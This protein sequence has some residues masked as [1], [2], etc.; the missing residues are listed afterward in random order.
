[1]VA[2][3][4]VYNINVKKMKKMKNKTVLI[5]LTLLISVNSCK[6]D[7]EIEDKQNKFNPL[8]GVFTSDEC[9]GV[10]SLLSQRIAFPTDSSFHQSYYSFSGKIQS[11]KYG[12]LNAINLFA[13]TLSLNSNTIQVDSSNHYFQDIVGATGQT[14]YGTNI[15]FVLDGDSSNSINPISFTMY[16]PAEIR[17]N[18]P[19]LLNLYKTSVTN[20]ITWN[21]DPNNS[22]DVFIRVVYKGAISQHYD[23]NLPANDVVFETTVADNGTYT[24]PSNALN[25]IP[26]GGIAE[27]MIGRGNYEEI[28][29]NGNVIY[30]TA[31]S[32][33]YCNFDI[34]Q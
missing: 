2:G 28:D 10:F 29:N 14:L 26:I 9:V 20:T 27:V 13:G 25:N 4:N 24:L 21:A 7:V 31:S 16:V 23:P 1:M 18:S 32:I 17:I 22:K 11:P 5:F 19:Q 12:E 33:T 30:F 3:A 8:T 34:K 15:D 6:K